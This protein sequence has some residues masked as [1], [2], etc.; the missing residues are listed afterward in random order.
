MKPF[1]SG[2]SVDL[3]ETLD[4]TSAE[5][6]RRAAAGAGGPRWILA[7]RQTA[8]YGR[9]GRH[10]EQDSGDFAGSLLFTPDAPRDRLGQF[11]FIA[12]LAVYEALA[13]LAPKA[14]LKIKWPNDILAGKAKLAGLLLEMVEAA[15]GPKLILGIGVNIVSKPADLPY[16]ATRLLDHGL[17]GPVTPADLAAAI[18]RN[19][20]AHHDRWGDQGFAPVRAAWLACAAGVGEAITVRL[21]NET[22]SGI[23]ED[24]DESGALILRFSGG[25]RIINAGDVYFGG[26]GANGN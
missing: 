17:P 6:K 15:G 20:W 22:V 7:L 16:P 14:R 21:P 19:F 9:R 11:S 5:A 2:A 13:G 12:A 25:T 1:P 8:G 26:A 24:L 10:W 23:F 3:Y 4:S 18:D